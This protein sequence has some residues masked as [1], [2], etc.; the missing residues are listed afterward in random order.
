MSQSRQEA[1]RDGTHLAAEMS[2]IE[3]PSRSPDA[4]AP[5]STRHLPLTQHAREHFSQ[6]LAR[7]RLFHN[8]ISI[9]FVDTVLADVSSAYRRSAQAKAIFCRFTLASLP[10]YAAPQPPL[11]LPARLCH[12]RA[13]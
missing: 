1:R 7:E 10:G 5:G 13:Q 3:L 9:R 11:W 12:G 4:D 6:N 8:S 2:L